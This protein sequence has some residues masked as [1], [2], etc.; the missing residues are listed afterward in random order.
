[1][2]V[3]STHYCLSNLKWNMI[4]NYKHFFFMFMSKLL[5]VCIIASTLALLIHLSTFNAWKFYVCSFCTI[6]SRVISQINLINVDLIVT[7]KKKK[8]S[9][10]V[11]WTCFYGIYL[12]LCILYIFHR[13][14]SCIY[15]VS[16][17]CVIICFILIS[18]FFVSGPYCKSTLFV[19]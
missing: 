10:Y 6:S 18:F 16:Y 8:L 9:S 12:Y 5:C 19:E 13:R 7:F 14:H 1:M 2:F 3:K 15:F 4:L 11:K 17:F